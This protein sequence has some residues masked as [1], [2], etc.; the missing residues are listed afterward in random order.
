MRTMSL[1]FCKRFIKVDGNV[2]MDSRLSSNALKMYILMHGLKQGQ[3][4]SNAYYEK[5][6]KISQATV[7]RTRKELI[8]AGY[9]EVQKI[10][11]REYRAFLGDSK[12]SGLEV[13]RRFYK[14][15]LHT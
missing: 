15:E 8:V 5:A 7:T 6:M 13:K 11:K 9:L 1:K 10:S 4:A 12:I 3:F 2:V 14:D